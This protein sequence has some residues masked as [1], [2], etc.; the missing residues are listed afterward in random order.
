[1]LR[2]PRCP[3]ATHAHTHT[4]PADETQVAAYPPLGPLTL[5][6]KVFLRSMGLNEVSRKMVQNKKKEKEV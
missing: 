6:L 4:T 3:C 2:S 5:V 1:M